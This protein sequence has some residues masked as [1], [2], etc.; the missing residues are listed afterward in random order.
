M[1]SPRKSLES[2]TPSCCRS[3]KENS[4]LNGSRLD[5]EGLFFN[6]A[7]AS[8]PFFSTGHPFFQRGSSNSP[9]EPG[10]DIKE[11]NSKSKSNGTPLQE[12]IKDYLQKTY[13]TDLSSVRVH[14]DQNSHYLST[15]LQADAF[16][17]GNDIYF[18]KEK[19]NP[20]TTDGKKLIAHEVAH[21]VQSPNHIARNRSAPRPSNHCGQTNNISSLQHLIIQLWYQFWHP[22]LLREY[23]MPADMRPGSYY[24]QRTEGGWA[25]LEEDIGRQEVERLSSGN[26]IINLADLVDSATHEMWEIMHPSDQPG[27]KLKQ[28]RGYIARANFHCRGTRFG[29]GQRLVEPEFIPSRQRPLLIVTPLMAGLLQY[30]YSEEMRRLPATERDIILA[31]LLDSI[32]NRISFVMPDQMTQPAPSPQ[33]I[34]AARRNLATAAGVVA[35]ATAATVIIRRAAWRHFW[36]V[37]I[38]TF[39][40]RGAAAATLS[41]ADG[42]LP[43]GELLSLGL[44]LFTVVQ[45]VNDWNELW[46]RAE[47]IA[48]SEG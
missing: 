3:G 45:I 31:R 19:Y 11:F 16:T 8:P 46:Q 22:P 32:R 25:D 13:S 21:V 36:R 47:D 26:Y 44:A 12:D 14:T 28:L 27:Q 23:E 24:P 34:D 20:A 1:V 6:S 5:D 4:F 39:A 15:A 18:N 40:I 9:R 42:P 2:S 17:A 29:L 41:L 38:R 37:V 30:Y 33:V 43:F 35:T 7:P 48:Q 10:S